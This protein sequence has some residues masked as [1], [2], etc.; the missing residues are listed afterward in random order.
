MPR[1]ANIRFHP[2][3][4]L[5][6]ITCLSDSEITHRGSVRS[7]RGIREDGRAGPGKAVTLG[8]LSEA[9]V[10]APGG[11]PGGPHHIGWHFVSSSEERTE[12]AHVDWVAVRMRLPNRDIE[13][14]IPLPTKSG[15]AT[16]PRS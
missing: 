10:M 13:E 5:S 15:A 9:M 12:Q 16:E 3:A 8:Y 7:L 14:F 2:H 6:T 4:S 1:A 11:E